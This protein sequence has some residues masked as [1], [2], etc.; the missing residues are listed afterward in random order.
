[1]RLVNVIGGGQINQEL[2]L[3][4]LAIETDSEFMRENQSSGLILEE[5]NNKI[6]LYTSG[7]YMIMG[8]S[9]EDE[10]YET[11][12]WL[13]NE[14][15]KRDI[16]TGGGNV[17]IHNMVF[18]ISM[19]DKMDLPSL[20]SKLGTNT[21]EYEPETNPF[22]MYRPPG[23]DGTISISSSGEFVITGVASQSEAEEI[24]HHLKE[25][26]GI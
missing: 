4:K 7:K 22:L 25:E 23:H 6:M 14:L 11:N 17:T 16:E 9:S 12:S 20:I 8:A 18:K 5:N 2:D 19:D 15:E 10:L 26:L 13:I 1:M 24:Y 21:T 3:N